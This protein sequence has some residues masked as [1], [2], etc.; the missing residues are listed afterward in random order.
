MKSNVTIVSAILNYTLKKLNIILQYLSTIS[1]SELKISC[2]VPGT[3][4][5]RA[6]GTVFP[7]TET[8]AFV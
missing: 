7:P 5:M 2:F 4:M 3:G 1:E 8:G 6:K